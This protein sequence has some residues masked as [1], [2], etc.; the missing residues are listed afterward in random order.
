MTK[1]PIDIQELLALLGEKDVTIHLL[2]KEL[3]LLKQRIRKD[4]QDSSADN[5]SHAN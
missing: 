5:K 3:F 2:E 4:E 1:Q